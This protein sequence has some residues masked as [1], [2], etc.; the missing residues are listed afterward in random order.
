MR[1]GCDEIV[2]GLRRK[3]EVTRD[4]D[5]NHRFGRS[6]RAFDLRRAT[7]KK[8]APGAALQQAPG[9]GN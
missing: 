7:H 3:I 5:G 6:R 2:L 8:S 9:A 1:Q 4:A